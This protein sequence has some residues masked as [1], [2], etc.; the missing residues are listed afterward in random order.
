MS[1]PVLPGARRVA[2]AHEGEVGRIGADGLGNRR[3]PHVPVPGL[4]RHDTSVFPIAGLAALR[5]AEA[6]PGPV[7]E[8][9]PQPLWYCLA[10]RRLLERACVAEPGQQGLL[11]QQL[12]VAGL[13]HLGGAHTHVEQAEQD[14]VGGVNVDGGPH[15]VP[16]VDELQHL[17]RRIGVADLRDHSRRRM[18]PAEVHQRVPEVPA[19]LLAGAGG[20]HRDLHR[21]RNGVFHRVLDSDHVE[22]SLRFLHL[23]REI[24]GQRG[25]LAVP[26]S[27][28]EEDAA[29]EREADLGEHRRL[30]CGEAEALQGGAL[31][32]AVAVEEAREQMIAVGLVG[33]ALAAQRGDRVRQR[34]LAAGADREPLEGASLVRGLCRSLVLAVEEEAHD[35]ASFV[36]GHGGCKLELAVVDDA[37]DAAE[38]AVVLEDDVAGS[39]SGGLLEEGA[40]LVR[41]RRLAACRLM[42]RPAPA[43]GDL[44]EAGGALDQPAGDTAVAAELHEGCAQPAVALVALG[45]QAAAVGVH[46]T[47]APDPL[48]DGGVADEAAG[49]LGTAAPC[50]NQGAPLQAQPRCGRALHD[51]SPLPSRRRPVTA[52]GRGL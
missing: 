41:R 50:G 46:S 15:L 38:P 14:G 18:H 45:D 8:V 16:G 20:G 23:E 1:H 5:V 11:H 51:P 9:P 43:R 10:A 37:V 26:R 32:D 19:A 36:C 25:G 42:R 47:D 49:A 6:H 21:A 27:S 31:L 17:A 44:V 52:E 13:A 2:L 24:G 40:H 22:L 7:A 39:G 34:H 3:L 29:P 30:L 28:A 33:S 35:L 12:D 48:V 4:A